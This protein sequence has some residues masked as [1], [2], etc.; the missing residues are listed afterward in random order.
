MIIENLPGGARMYFG[1]E[2]KFCINLGK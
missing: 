2:D 1:M